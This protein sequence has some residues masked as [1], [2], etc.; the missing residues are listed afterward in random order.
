MGEHHLG[1]RAVR[2]E[3]DSCLCRP[4]LYGGALPSP[5][6]TL[7]LFEEEFRKYRDSWAGPA[8]LAKN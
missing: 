8:S 3:H 1:D 5:D 2:M 4:E 6:L 7:N